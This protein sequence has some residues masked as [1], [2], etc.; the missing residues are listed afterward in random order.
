MKTRIRAFTLAETLI[1]LG[2]LGVVM[3]MT[4][5]S[6]ITSYKKQVTVAKLQKAYS[7]LSQAMNAA[8]AKHGDSKYWPEWDAN[9]EVVLRTYFA[10]ELKNSKVYPTNADDSKLMCYERDYTVGF[11][12]TKNE[13]IKYPYAW[14]NDLYFSSPMYA[15]HTASMQLMDGTCVGLNSNSSRYYKKT[16]FVDINGPYQRP[17]KAGYDLFL[18][19]IRD[20]NIVP[21]GWD[22]GYALSSPSQINS[23]H[24]KA[25]NGGMFCAAKIMEDN[26][27]ITYW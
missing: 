15:T 20:N 5:P 24:P 4:L 23:C 27:Q 22:W 12:S 8:V 11:Q 19:E 10:P 6:I 3:A 13:N 1:T 16:V 17:N 26:W 7:V 2:I 18:F 14:M 21:L 9:A 25:N